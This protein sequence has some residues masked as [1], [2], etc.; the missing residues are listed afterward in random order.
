MHVTLM[1]FIFNNAIG[2]SSEAFYDD[3]LNYMKIEDYPSAL[4]SINNAIAIDSSQARFF[5][6]K[7]FVHLQLKQYEEA[8]VCHERA[9]RLEPKCDF[10]YSN[11]GNFFL[12][13]FEFDAAINDYNKAIKLAR[14]DSLKNFCLAH[15]GVA[16]LLKMDYR[17]AY[18]DLIKA[19]KFNPSDYV[20]LVNLSTVCGRMEKREESLKYLFIANEI[21][22]HDEVILGNI[23]FQFQ[24]LGEYEK[25]NQYYDAVIEMNPDAPLAYNNRS[26]NKYK[27]GDLDDA[28][29]DVNKSLSLYPENSYAYRNRALIFIKLERIEDA[30]YD[31]SRAIKLGFTQIYGDEVME[32]KRKYCDELIIPE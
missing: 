10:L 6:R 32:L 9:I 15:R 5:D 12:S 1:F 31:F 13:I 23:G 18:K 25:S 30:C 14:H 24:Q 8:F 20:V 11:R 28:L 26:Y 17:G 4:K 19:Y 16:K 27:L 7:A 3:A 22:P 21:F 2:Q 29:K